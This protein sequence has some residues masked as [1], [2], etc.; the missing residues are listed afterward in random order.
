MSSTSFIQR[1]LLATLFVCLVVTVGCLDHAGA[2]DATSATAAELG[3]DSTEAP[4][5]DGRS[6]L[7]LEPPAEFTLTV[8]GDVMLDRTVWRRIQSNGTSSIFERVRADLRG[9]D[10]CFANLECPLSTVGPHAPSEYCI[11]RADPHAVDVLLDGGIDVVALA[12][13][14]TLNS[15]TEAL[16]QTMDHLDEA[17]VAYCGANRQR[18]RSWEP[19]RFE[20]A[21][22]LIGFIACTDLSFEHGS[23][24]KVD[25]EMTDFARRVSAAKSGCD[26]LVVSIHWGNEYQK[27]PTD[28][29]QRV[30]H[31]AIDA[32]GNLIIGHHPHT[33]QGVGEYRG[34]PILYSCG[35]FVFDQREG[36]RMESAIFHLHYTE[37]ER[38]QIRMDPVWIPRSRCGP[39]YP[40]PGR[41]AKI[42]KRLATL[43]ANLGVPVTVTN[44]TGRASIPVVGEE[45]TADSTSDEADP[46]GEPVATTATFE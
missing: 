34:S 16:M 5:D 18:E 29:Q 1:L 10:I 45:S 7:P 35:N 22:L 24:C 27:V 20:V 6:G 44:N 42:I 38:W 25:D 9:A 19:C 17:G 3:A 36:E 28:R 2:P 15:G 23:W 14:H 8:V 31:A 4:G 30:A 21:G 32:G 13:N 46:A 43:S 12:N 11:F 39:I 40:E 26:L 41:A 33:L 37:G